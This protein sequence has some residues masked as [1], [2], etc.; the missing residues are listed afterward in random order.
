MKSF[1]SGCFLVILLVLSVNNPMGLTYAMGVAAY[2]LQ[3]PLR[4]FFSFL[5]HPLDFIGLGIFFG[6]CTEGFA[7]LDNLKRLPENRILIDA[8][9]MRDLFFGFFFYGFFILMWYVLLRRWRFSMRQVF[10]L[11]GIFGI[12]TEQFNPAAGGPVILLQVITNPFLG[13]PMAF[14]I[15]CVYGIFPALAYLLTEGRFSA[16]R[17]QVRW[18]GYCFAIGALLLQWAIY[19]NIILPFLRR[20]LS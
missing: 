2:L 1:F 13:I 8:D 6:L 10:V 16:K 4:K 19:G 14:L 18:R 7:I 17:M 3:N 11:S 9:P 20:I 15:A 12:L 5:P